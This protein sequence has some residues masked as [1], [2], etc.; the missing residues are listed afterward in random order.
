MC[1]MFVVVRTARQAFVLLLLLEIPLNHPGEPSQQPLAFRP[2]HHPRSSS[3]ACAAARTASSVPALSLLSAGAPLS[4][5]TSSPLSQHPRRP[6]STSISLP[7]LA[8]L[9]AP[10]APTSPSGPSGPPPAATAASRNSRS[11][12]RSGAH[13][14]GLLTNAMRRP[15]SANRRMGQGR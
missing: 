8:Y 15:S 9:P 2:A 6:C 13:C 4:H 3:R 5:S 7:S 11:A 14:T 12:F 10:S 1:A